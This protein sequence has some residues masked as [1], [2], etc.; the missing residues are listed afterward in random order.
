[1]DLLGLASG[2]A[3]GESAASSSLSSTS[4]PAPGPAAAT[5]SSASASTAETDAPVIY[6]RVD[7]ENEDN[8]ELL[9]SVAEHGAL[10]RAKLLR[11]SPVQLQ[12]SA[13]R[14]DDATMQGT[15]AS[16]SSH[17]TTSICASVLHRICT[18]AI[19]V[20]IS[21]FFTFPL[22]LFYPSFSAIYNEIQLI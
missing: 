9:R 21:P 6:G 5:S 12:P 11:P 3:M 8:L 10:G 2:K 22:F 14:R 4:T 18:G 1:M 17:H 20:S 19:R 13:Q 7:A 15:A 16:P